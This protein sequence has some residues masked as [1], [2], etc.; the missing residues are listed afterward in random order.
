MTVCI[1]VHVFIILSVYVHLC[2]C[3]YM[4]PV[5]IINFIARVLLE[6]IPSLVFTS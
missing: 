2:M 4:L 1:C 3:V 5:C 6:I